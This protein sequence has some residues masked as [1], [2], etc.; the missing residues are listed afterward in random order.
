MIV[1]LKPKRGWIKIVEVFAAILIIASVVLIVLQQDRGEEDDVYYSDAKPYEK[2][3]KFKL[4][5]KKGAEIIELPLFGA[6]NIINFL[7]A[8]SIAL[9]LGL[10]LA[11]LL[12]S[13]PQL[14]L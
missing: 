3:W 6:H 13:L 9:K 12:Y 14:L 7:A 11:G 5:T 4:H 1:G 10:V 8:S 2:G